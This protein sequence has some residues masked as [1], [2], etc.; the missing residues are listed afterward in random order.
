MWEAAEVSTGRRSMI[1]HVIFLSKFR[2]NPPLSA[3][4]SLPC[5]FVSPS[6]TPLTD[7]GPPMNQVVSPPEPRCLAYGTPST[8][9]GMERLIPSLLI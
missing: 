5:A 8:L 4:G 7:A 2:A 3:S 6:R 9:F 1:D